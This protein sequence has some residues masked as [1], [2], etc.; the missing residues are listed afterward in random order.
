MHRLARL[1]AMALLIT[2]CAATAPTTQQ[3]APATPVA[4][5]LPATAA[6]T[7]VRATVAVATTDSADTPLAVGVDAD[8]Y[9]TLGDPAAPV[10]LT[11]YSDYF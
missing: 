6:A 7:P 1:S 4:T 5:A 2:A 3:S 10:T 9:H 11:D 8:G